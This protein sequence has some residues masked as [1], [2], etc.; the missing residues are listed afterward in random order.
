MRGHAEDVSVLKFSP[1]SLHLASGS[2][3]NS[4]RIWNPEFGMLE[5]IFGAHQG[6]V[7][8][9]GYIGSGTILFSASKDKS[10]IAWDMIKMGTLRCDYTPQQAIR[11]TS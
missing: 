9:L 5:T 1:D 8:G 11:G 6:K 2:G 4:V 10:I 7:H 3:D